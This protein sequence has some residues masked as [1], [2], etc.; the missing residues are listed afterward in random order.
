MNFIHKD[1]IFADNMK[2]RFLLPFVLTLALLATSCHSS[3]KTARNSG[4]ERQSEFVDTPK[5]KKK[6]G[7]GV[8]SRLAD[9][10]IEESRRWL[11]TPYKYGGCTRKG[12]DCSGM[13]MTIYLDIAG[14]KLPRQSRM[15]QEFCRKISRKELAPGDLV[16]FTV[17]SGSSRVGHVGIYIGKGEFIHSSSSKGVVISSLDQN[18]Y[19]RHFHSCGRVP[20]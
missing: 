19:V 3:K 13:V 2:A 15:Q 10:I 1:S 6:K 5:D 12:T 11:G 18:Y 20:L 17:K 7:K 16:F 4:Y 8:D 9:R 14:V